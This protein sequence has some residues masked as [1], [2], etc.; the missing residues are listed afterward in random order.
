MKIEIKWKTW[1]N[2][3]NQAWPD[4]FM[5]VFDLSWS[6]PPLLWIGP[7][8][9]CEHILL[10]LNCRTLW[11]PNKF[12]QTPSTHQKKSLKRVQEKLC[13]L[14]RFCWGGWNTWW[15]KHQWIE[16][17]TKLVWV[18]FWFCFFEMRKVLTNSKSGQPSFRGEEENT[19]CVCPSVLF[20]IFQTLFWEIFRRL[21]VTVIKKDMLSFVHLILLELSSSVSAS[22]RQ[23]NK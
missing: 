4:I 9:M 7:R 11:T 20:A 22:E 8:Q 3:R 23:T 19:V 1:C 5:S 6:W 14:D 13:Y 12:Y 17:L 2:E 21:S 15:S 16:C 10:S 18:A